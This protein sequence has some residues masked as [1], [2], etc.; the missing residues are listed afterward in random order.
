MS[1]IELKPEDRVLFV[2]NDNTI[3]GSTRFQKYAFLL[4]M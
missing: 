2:I 3:H 4:H 1:D